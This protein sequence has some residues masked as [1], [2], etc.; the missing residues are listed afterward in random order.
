MPTITPR[1]KA[2]TRVPVPDRFRMFISK[3][4]EL[5]ESGDEAA[6]IPSDDLLQSDDVY[7][8]LTDEGHYAFVFFPSSG[9]RTKWEITLTREDISAIATGQVV[10]LDLWRCHEESCGCMFSSRTGL[11]FHCDY[12][13]DSPERTPEGRLKTR[14]ERALAFYALQPGA[15]P[16]QMI[17]TYNSQPH[18]GEEFGIFSLDEAIAILADFRCGRGTDAI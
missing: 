10:V 13:G 9:G 2:L 8:G 11:C 6:L 1:V 15:H 18:L 7:G 14:R 3:V 5:I 12:V 4:H 17:G 16:L